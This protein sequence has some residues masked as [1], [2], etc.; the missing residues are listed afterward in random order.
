[1]IEIECCDGSDE[2][3][4]ICPNRCHEVGAVYRE[5]LEAENKIRKTVSTKYT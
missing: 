4:G 2:S 1:M 3:S 5:K